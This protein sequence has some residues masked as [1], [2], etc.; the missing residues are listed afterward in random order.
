VGTAARSELHYELVA[1]TAG[2]FKDK[3]D[4]ALTNVRRERFTEPLHI[5]RSIAMV[6]RTQPLVSARIVLRKWGARADGA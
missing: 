2:E 6:G 1:G 4:E 3:L 5:S